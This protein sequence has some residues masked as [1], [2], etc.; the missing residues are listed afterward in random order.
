MPLG[1]SFRQTGCRLTVLFSLLALGACGNSLGE[2]SVKPLP[3]PDPYPVLLETGPLADRI[4]S[5]RIEVTLDPAEHLLH[6]HSVLSWRNTGQRPLD[7]MPFH[8]Y[9]NAFKNEASV[10]MQESRGRHRRAR[11]TRDGWG[12]IEVTSIQ[13]AGVELIDTVRYPHEPDE[14]VMELPLPAPLMPGASVDVAMRFEVKLPE[15]F[16]RTGYKGAF[17]MVGQWFPKPGKLIGPAGSERWHCEPF[18]L[19]SEFFADFGTYDVTISAPSTH[20][21]VGTGVLKDVRD[22]DDGMRT[23]I[24]RA[25]DVHDFVWMADPYMEVMSD[26]ATTDNGPV[27][28]RVYHRPRQREFARRHLHAGIGAIE[29]FSRLYRTYPWPIM[30]IID[31]PLDAASGAGGM[32]Y[33]TVV[34][35]AGDSAF[36]R[37]GIRLGEFVTVHEVGHNWFQGMLAS[38]EVDEAWL[39][40]GINDYADWVVMNEIYGEGSNM[41]DWQGLR[42]DSMELSTAAGRIS[43]LAAAIDTRS[44]E[45]PNN[46]TYGAATYGKT[47]A[48]M[49]SLEAAVGRERFRAAFRTYSQRYAFRHPTGEDLFRTLEESLGPDVRPYLVAAFRDIGSAAFALKDLS[50]RKVHEPRGVFGRGENRRT[51]TRDDAPDSATWRCDILVANLGRIPIPVD[52][53]VTFADG[54]VEMHRFEPNADRSWQRITVERE[55]KVEQVRIDPDRQIVINTTPAAG[56]YRETPDRAASRRAAARVGFWA[57][58]AMQVTGL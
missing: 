21:V 14:T 15:V 54:A 32:E 49:R 50:C 16:A 38:N 25:E 36:L 39:D 33:P 46:A 35:T 19:N 17:H 44:Y 9:M 12:W 29:Q 47:A 40:E 18:H 1:E 31:P 56:S 20:V 57:Q 53:E 51:V 6:A 5:Y 41:L 48:V 34:T 26:T 2:P 24:Y 23:H 55:S 52:V 43:R 37:P 8:L 45:F 11:A 13:I 4:A 22:G 3:A 10:F 58:T 7:S 30:S 27:Q 42:G 28:V